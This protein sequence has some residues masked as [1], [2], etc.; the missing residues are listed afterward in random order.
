MQSRAKK[1]ISRR[2]IVMWREKTGWSREENE[3]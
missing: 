3:E 2:R 1:R